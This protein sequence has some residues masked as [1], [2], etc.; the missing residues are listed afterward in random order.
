M[1]NFAAIL[2][3]SVTL[4]SGSV[5]QA[6]PE[7]P[8]NAD[9]LPLIQL[10][11]DLMLKYLSAELAFQRGQAA[12]AHLAM[13]TLARSSGD[14]RLARRATEMAIAASSATDALKG[15]KL[16]REL[17][18]GSDEAFQV[19]L[20]LQ[21]NNNRLDEANRDRDNANRFVCFLIVNRLQ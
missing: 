10:S 4:A 21:L 7:T 1:K 20:S 15:A 13:M 5:A 6:A 17:A 16:W 12:G 8:T 9:G 14:P 11:E 2:T 19:L 18:P 3:L